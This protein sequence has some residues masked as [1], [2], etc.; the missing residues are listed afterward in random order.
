MVVEYIKRLILVLLIA[1][2]AYVTFLVFPTLV[3]IFKFL[4]KIILPFIIAFAISFI[5][6]PIINWLQIRVK[7]RGLAVLI[8]MILFVG[9]IVFLIYTS[10]PILI[11][12]LKEF[13]IQLPAI[14]EQL[15]TLVD[16]FAKKLDFL[17]INYQPT[18]ENL[19][20]F[21]AKYI[22]N[23][24]TISGDIF[25]KLLSYFSIL[26]LIPMILVH[27]LLDYEKILCRFRDYLV[28]SNKIH[29]K[30]YLGE[31]NQAMSSYFRGAFLVMLIL[32]LAATAAFLIVG[33]DFAFFFGIIIGI[34]NI[35]PYLGPYI[36][37]TFPV[38]Y[39][40]LDSPNKAI[41]IIV[42]IFILQNLENNFVSPYIHSRQTKTHPL[43]VL[44]F[45]SIFGRLFGVFGMLIAVPILSIVKITFKY[46]PISNIKIKRN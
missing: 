24:T 46:Y 26:I 10:V 12:E 38:I 29:F 42:I 25:S 19:N 17:P 14:L 41:T 9:L 22:N 30:N 11:S 32:T 27:F 37:A 36:G 21:L 5:L 6:Q 23:L 4:L 20:N 3:Y 13:I 34:T 18:F 7:K 31:L 39:A 35:I 28:K 1:V 33:L 43:L 8:V 2:T 16:N 15:E 45:L 44:L 40:L